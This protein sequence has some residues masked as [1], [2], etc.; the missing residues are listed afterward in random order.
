MEAFWFLVFSSNILTE[1]FLSYIKNLAHFG[2]APKTKF[3]TKPKLLTWFVV[4]KVSVKF[5][6]IVF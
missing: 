5:I 3:D 6:F 1:V 4:E 2:V